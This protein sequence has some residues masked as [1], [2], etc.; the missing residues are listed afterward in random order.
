MWLL[1]LPLCLLIE[2]KAIEKQ[3][4][5]I[6][7]PLMLKNKSVG[8]LRISLLVSLLKVQVPIASIPNKTRLMSSASLKNSNIVKATCGLTFCLACAA[9][10][11]CAAHGV[12]KHSLRFGRPK[13]G[14]PDSQA[15]SCCWKT[16]RSWER[17]F[18]G[19]WACDE[20]PGGKELP[21]LHIQE[22]LSRGELRTEL[23]APR[24]VTV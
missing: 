14:F 21:N 8:V 2:Y 12:G 4:P 6:C 20:D 5:R 16:E 24:R 13:M 17:R 18:R 22:P 11:K 1:L 19:P 9:I 15:S 3:Y 23:G 10:V 7:I